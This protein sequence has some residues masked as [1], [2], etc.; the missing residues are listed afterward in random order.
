MPLPVTILNAFLHKLM[1]ERYNGKMF[2][3]EIAFC[4]SLQSLLLDIPLTIKRELFVESCR[5][6]ISCWVVAITCKTLSVGATCSSVFLI[7][8]FVSLSPF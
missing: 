1:G 5:E 7:V 6:D 3:N 8:S 4:M 2:G